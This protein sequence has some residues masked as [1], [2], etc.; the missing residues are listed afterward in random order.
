MTDR[1]NGT[2]SRI[3]TSSSDYF[4]VQAICDTNILDFLERISNSSVLFHIKLT[5][6]S[7]NNYTSRP[8]YLEMSCVCESV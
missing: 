6:N 2:S 7:V 5:D 8:H 1:I 3:D 4:F